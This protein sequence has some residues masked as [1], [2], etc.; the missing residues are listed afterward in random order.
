MVD[1]NDPLDADSGTTTLQNFPVVDSVTATTVS[2]TLDSEPSKS[3][4]VE[5]YSV[6]S[7]DPS[8]NGEARPTSAG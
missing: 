1:A 2:G 7:C 4:R 8:G 3:Y 5:V 6:P